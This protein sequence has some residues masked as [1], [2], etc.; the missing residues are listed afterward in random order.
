MSGKV[1][2]S[3]GSVN[4]KKSVINI[5]AKRI[6]TLKIKLF[7]WINIDADSHVKKPIYL[8]CLI[9]F[10]IKY[11][12]LGIFPYQRRTVFKSYGYKRRD[13]M[14]IRKNNPLEKVGLGQTL[15]C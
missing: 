11:A 5:L 15:G 13:T 9:L 12:L 14:I 8:L 6:L 3:S 2:S 1:F 10:D 4:G 7:G